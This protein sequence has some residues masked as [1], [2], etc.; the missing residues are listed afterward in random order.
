MERDNRF[1]QTHTE[2]HIGVTVRK[3][4]HELKAQTSDTHTVT[5]R[6]YC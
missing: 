5:L 6:Q 1:I 3:S 4:H 2:A